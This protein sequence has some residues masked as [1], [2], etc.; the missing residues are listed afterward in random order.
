MG[1]VFPNP[2]KIQPEQIAY[3]IGQLI[4]AKDATDD[5]K[6]EVFNQF[7]NDCENMKIIVYSASAGS[8]FALSS[9]LKKK[10]DTEKENFFQG[11][12][13]KLFPDVEKEKKQELQ[14]NAQKLMETIVKKATL[15]IIRQEF[16]FMLVWLIILAE[17]RNILQWERVY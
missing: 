4:K 13:A 6:L 9:F 17:K 14:E 16:C 1:N 7:R 5:K 10:N 11:V 15:V 12:V 2:N 8:F 3:F